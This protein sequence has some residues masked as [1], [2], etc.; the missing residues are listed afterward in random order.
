M[1][2]SEIKKN[3][4]QTIYRYSTSYSVL[5]YENSEIK[6]RELIWNS[7]NLQ[8][9]EYVYDREGFYQLTYVGIA[10]GLQ[11]LVNFEPE[12]GSR[13]LGYKSKESYVKGRKKLAELY[14]N[15]NIGNCQNNYEDFVTYFALCCHGIEKPRLELLEVTKD[16]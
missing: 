8:P 10:P 9:P 16:V 15:K 7:T 1:K 4:N 5:I 12:L 6:K 2:L 11:N 14:W 13:Y 3:K